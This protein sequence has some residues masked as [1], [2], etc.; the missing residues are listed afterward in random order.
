MKAACWSI[1]FLRPVGSKRLL[2]RRAVGLEALQT[3]VY[4]LRHA[5]VILAMASVTL[6]DA[7]RA[8]VS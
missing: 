2:R 4:L 3:V 7:E 8:F 5:V 6:R 1:A